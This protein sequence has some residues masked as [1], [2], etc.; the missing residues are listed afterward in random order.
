MSVFWKMLPVIILAAV[1]IALLLAMMMNEFY[2]CGL[3]YLAVVFGFFAV[4]VLQISSV[5]ITEKIKEMHQP[6]KYW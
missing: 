2:N 3:S 1:S 6:L 4:G 5:Y